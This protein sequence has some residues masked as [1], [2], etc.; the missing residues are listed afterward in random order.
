M[1]AD[2]VW[3]DKAIWWRDTFAMGDD[4]EYVEQ[5]LPLVREHVKGA[6]RVLD[7]G[8]GEGQIARTVKESAETVVAIDSAKAMIEQANLRSDGITFM[9]ADVSNLPF[10]DES[11]DAVT[12]CLVIEHVDDMPKAISEI[13]RVLV[14]GG[15]FLLLINHPLLQTPNSG[16]IDDHILEEQYWRIGPYLTENKSMEEVEAGV[17]IPFIHRPLSTY[18]NTMAA[19]GLFVTQMVE[20]APPPGFIARAEEYEEAATIPRLLMLR[21]EKLA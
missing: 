17:F 15:R 12:T 14:R 16:W 9:R 2:P 6:Q 7:I 18:I 5:I 1:T 20:P 10:E 21:T 13:S 19:N 4:P 8:T 3:E 11:F